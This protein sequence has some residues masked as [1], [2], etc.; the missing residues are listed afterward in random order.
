[1]DEVGTVDE[2]FSTLG[3]DGSLVCCFSSDCSMSSAMEGSGASSG[4]SLV[5]PSVGGASCCSSGEGSVLLSGNIQF[6]HCSS[7]IEEATHQTFR[8][9][10]SI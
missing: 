2:S 3:P 9:I 6:D 8:Y 7:F 4:V 5:L 10:A 1:M